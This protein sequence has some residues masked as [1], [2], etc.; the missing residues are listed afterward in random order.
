MR[1]LALLLTPSASTIPFH[2]ET[3]CPTV[4]RGL[5]LS[6][7]VFLFVVVN[8]SFRFDTDSAYRALKLIAP[9]RTPCHFLDP[10]KKEI[11]LSTTDLMSCAPSELLSLSSRTLSLRLDSPPLALDLGLQSTKWLRQTRA[12][13]A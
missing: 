5:R 2:R 10:L 4:A 7:N 8:Q 11:P 6:A 3:P 9:E 13:A 12:E 1:W